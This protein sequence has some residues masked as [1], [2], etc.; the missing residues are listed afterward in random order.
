MAPDVATLGRMLGMADGVPGT[1]LGIRVPR[2]RRVVHVIN[3]LA[4]GGAETMLARI[5]EAADIGSFEHIV[6]PLLPG[7]G[8]EQR[9]R[10]TGALVEPLGVHGARN[11]LT[12]PYRLAA[13]LK[14][15]RPDVVQGWLLQGNLAATIATGLAR[16]RAPVLWNVRWTLYDVESEPRR[17]RALLRLSGLLARFPER[18]VYNSR[19]AVAQHAAIG[20]PPR[21]ARV[22]PNGFDLER[23]RP[24]PAA[25]TAM[26]LEFGIPPGAKVIGMLARYHPMKDHATSLRAAA[27]LVER[28]VDAVFVYAGRGVDDTNA[29]VLDLVERLGL[30]SRVRLLGERQDVARLYAS[31]DLYWMSSLARGI[32]EGFPNVIAEAMACG[33]PCVST[34]SGDAA[35]IIGQTGHVVSSGDPQA[36]GD[37]AAE[38]LLSDPAEIRRMSREARARIEAEFS[39]ESVVAAYEALYAEVFDGPKIAAT[40]NS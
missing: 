11:L 33:V 4:T 23:L 38:L 18:I 20:F 29:E 3:S 37:A 32:A 16:V 24:D 34:D 12:A 8:V 40:E 19:L 17:T 2:R 1:A 36:L 13:R 5:V 9:I 14:Q 30:S 15:L 6:L 35:W 27:R 39:L 26:R 31:F 25:R 7:G 10:N 28:G 21:Q 22:I